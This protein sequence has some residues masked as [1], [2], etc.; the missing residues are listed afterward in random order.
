MLWSYAADE[1]AATLVELGVYHD[2]GASRT[3]R[4]RYEGVDT[5]NG[6]Q[7]PLLEQPFIIVQ[8]R[9]AGR[10]RTSIDG[11]EDV[12]L[13]DLTVDFPGPRRF[14]MGQYLD[15]SLAEIRVYNSAVDDDEVADIVS[16]LA[17]TYAIAVQR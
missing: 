17:R 6:K 10:V 5:Y 14:R 16:G 7:S 12:F 13:P 11:G 15:G 3:L 2:H 9:V 1:A 8:R 4:T